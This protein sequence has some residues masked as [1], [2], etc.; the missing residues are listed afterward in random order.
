MQSPLLS[1]IPAL[2]DG[3]RL[4]DKGEEHYLSDPASGTL[5]ML[6]NYVAQRIVREVDGRSAVREICDRIGREFGDVAPSR[7]QQD[8]VEMFDVLEQQRL[9]VFHEHD[10]NG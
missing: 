2:Q 8:V 7:I 6:D 10:G 1:V 9:I 5:A 3:V 4:E